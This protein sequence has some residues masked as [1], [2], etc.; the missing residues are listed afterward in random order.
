MEMLSA[1][2]EI[3]KATRD[4]VRGYSDKALSRSLQKHLAEMNRHKEILKNATPEQVRSITKDIM[5]H[6]DS[7]RAIAEELSE[8]GLPIIF[9]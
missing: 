9:K 8:R 7:M 4:S 6:E 3:S 1:V 2:R 5:K